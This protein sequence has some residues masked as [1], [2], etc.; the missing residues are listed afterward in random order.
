MT[1]EQDSLQ[2]TMMTTNLLIDLDRRPLHV[3][4]PQDNDDSGQAKELTISTSELLGL[5]TSSQM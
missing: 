3:Q 5:Q 4:Q 1:L 2:A